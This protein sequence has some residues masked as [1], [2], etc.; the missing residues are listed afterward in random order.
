MLRRNGRGQAAVEA[1]YKC[2]SVGLCSNLPGQVCAAAAAAGWCFP[3]WHAQQAQP[4]LETRPHGP[5]NNARY[6]R[7]QSWLTGWLGRCWGR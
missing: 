7:P 5:P 4:L 3:W 6:S 2:V 1:V